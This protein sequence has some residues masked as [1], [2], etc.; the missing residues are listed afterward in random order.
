LDELLEL[1][2]NREIKA[3]EIYE[4]AAGQT[5]GDLKKLLEGLAV[6]EREH[7]ER[8]KKMRLY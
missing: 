4:G 7:E 2:V 5:R 6:F 3:A 1:A 8:L